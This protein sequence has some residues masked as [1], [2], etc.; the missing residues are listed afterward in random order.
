MPESAENSGKDMFN[1]VLSALT[2]VRLVFFF[3]FSCRV[4]DKKVT[5]EICHVSQQ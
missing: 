1:V 2:E 3:F 5:E 4:D